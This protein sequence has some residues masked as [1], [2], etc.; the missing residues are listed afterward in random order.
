MSAYYFKMHVKDYTEDHMKNVYAAYNK[1]SESE[2]EALN[3]EYQK[4]I[5]F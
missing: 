5:N 4:V 2:K 1:I 3:I